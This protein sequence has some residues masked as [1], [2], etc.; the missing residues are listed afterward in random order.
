[1]LIPHIETVNISM[2][3]TGPY[4]LGNP[5]QVGHSRFNNGTLEDFMT[6][7]GLTMM[8]IHRMLIMVPLSG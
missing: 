7:L 8:Y 3:S 6:L 4:L 2:A 1:M 5:V